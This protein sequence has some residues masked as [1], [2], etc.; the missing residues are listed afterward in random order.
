MEF[1]KAFPSPANTRVMLVEN[2]RSQQYIIEAAEHLVKG[3]SAITGKKARASGLAAELPLSPVKVFDRDEAALAE[4][5]IEHYQRGETVLML[6]RKTSDKLLIEKHLSQ[7]AKVDSSLPPSQRRLRQLTYHSAKG[8]QA[9]TVF[10]LGDCQY[11]TSSPYKNQVYRL[12]GLGKPADAQ[13]FDTAQKEEVQRLAYVAV[14]RAVRQCYWHVE[15]AS[16]EAA[17]QALGS[18]VGVAAAGQA[19]VESIFFLFKAQGHAVHPL[20]VTLA[21]DGFTQGLAILAQ[22]AATQGLGQRFDHR[23]F[24][25]AVEVVALKVVHAGVPAFSEHLEPGSV[26][27]A[28]QASP[29]WL[30]GDPLAASLGVPVPGVDF[31]QHRFLGPRR[32]FG[33]VAVQHRLLGLG[34]VQA[35]GQAGTQ[36]QAYLDQV[37]AFTDAIVQ[38]V[39]GQ[40]VKAMQGWQHGPGATLGQ[41]PGG[42]GIPSAQGISPSYAGVEQVLG[43][44]VHLVT[45]EQA[46]EE[47]EQWWGGDFRACGLIVGHHFDLQGA[48][49]IGACIATA[50]REL[51]GHV[52]QACT[53]ASTGACALEQCP[54]LAGKCSGMAM[55]TGR[56]AR[57]FDDLAQAGMLVCE[58]R[59]QQGGQPRYLFDAV[60]AQVHHPQHARIAL[61]QAA[62][63]SRPQAQSAAIQ[64]QGR[65]VVQAGQVGTGGEGVVAQEQ[66]AQW[67][68][69]TE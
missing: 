64:A 32:D 57:L 5:V 44:G 6:F 49:T 68:H 62:Q 69:R 10:M 66:V 17:G 3:A 21:G 4:T 63:P 52:V 65:E 56:Q 24:E 38:H 16:G 53:K 31:L 13:A 30:P 50:H 25:R 43:Q 27:L 46:P 36:G 58:G 41:R 54:Y 34:E 23:C 14:T 51:I 28:Q 39:V 20:D 9:D 29:T 37:Q 12:A 42:P 2:Y 67:S 7:I 45:P 26:L 48:E 1:T 11:L 35:P 60:I 19:Q 18:V 15:K 22:R 61:H 59:G 47:L 40:G 33:R 55:G 8:L